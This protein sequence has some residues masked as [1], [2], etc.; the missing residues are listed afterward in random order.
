[1]KIVATILARD[2]EDIIGANIE[3]H[4]NQGISQF[5]LTDNGSKDKTKEIAAKYPEVVEIIDEPGNDHRQSEWVTRM[6]RMACK[7]SPDWIVHLD[8][9]ELW[10]GLPSLRNIQGA[11]AGCTG[12]YLHPPTNQVFSLAT[13]RHYLD[14][15]NFKLPGECKIAHRPNPNIVVTHGNHGV[16][17]PPIEFTDKIWRHHYPIRSFSQFVRKTVNGHE[18]LLRRNSICARWE[19]WYNLHI[20]GSLGQLYETVC[21]EWENMIRSPNLSSLLKL[22]EYWSTPEAV[23]F[24]ANQ[25]QLPLIGEW[26]KEN[27]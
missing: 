25:K 24:I 8:A 10:G 22:I 23:Q 21:N 9:D 1:M 20:A 4:V 26:P 27:Q 7:L 5:I 16:E 19:K 2:E 17:G 12:M 13:M 6:A 18:S 3:H 15:D 11:V 14:F